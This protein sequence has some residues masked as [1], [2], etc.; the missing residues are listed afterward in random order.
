MST[1][2]S[3]FEQVSRRAFMRRSMALGAV[4]LGAGALAACGKDD[5][6]VFAADTTA[7]GAETTAAAAATT[8]APAAETTVAAETTAA[9]AE[10][11]AAAA[12]AGALPA[13]AQLAIDFTFAAA[14]SGGRVHNPYVAVWIENEAEEMID[15]VE[16]WLMTGKG[17]RW[18]SHMTRW[19]ELDQ[20]RVAAGGVDTADTITSATKAAGTYSVLWDGTDYSGAKVAAGTYY[21]CLEASREKGP[22]ELIREPLTLGTEGFTQALADNGELTGASV[23]YGV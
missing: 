20:A 14:D 8:A 11:T 17:E 3:R 23:T 15:T 18:W 2:A 6:E 21:V 19:Y 12:T 9:A 16:L 10:T 1:D 4:V 13:T 5:A 7:T 22:Y